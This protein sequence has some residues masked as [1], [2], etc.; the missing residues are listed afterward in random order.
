MKKLIE[1]YNGLSKEQQ[2]KIDK[3]VMPI[4]KGYYYTVIFTLQLIVTLVSGI[5]GAIIDYDYPVS[6]FILGTIIGLGVTCYT[7]SKN[8]WL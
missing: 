2:E 8:E 3:V 4:I 1:M 5:T 6:G 7:I